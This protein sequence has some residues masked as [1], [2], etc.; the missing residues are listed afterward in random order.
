MFGIGRIIGGIIEMGS[1][2]IDGKVER[3]KI[4]E[5]AKAESIKTQLDQKG[6]WELAQVDQGGW[7]DEWLTLLI[8]IPL[9]ASF[10][11]GMEGW[12]SR[13]FEVLSETPEWY[14]HLVGVVFAAA[15]GVREL[16]LL[17]K[18]IKQIKKS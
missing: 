12:V 13:G 11:P 8:S 17:G 2:W 3:Q 18:R 9:I 7:K 6:S 16:T 14:R 10:V 4:K 15:F 5:V 1:T